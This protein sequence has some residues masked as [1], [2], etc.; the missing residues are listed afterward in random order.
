MD[1][2]QPVTPASSTELQA[3]CLGAASL[4][5]PR[6]GC[7]RELVLG[8]GK[9]LA[10]LVYLHSAPTR[11][12]SREHL[13]DLLWADLDPTA[14][15]HALRQTLWYLRQRLGPDSIRTDNG[16][17]ALA[18]DLECDRDDFVRAVTDG[19][20]E[21]AVA[22][23]AGHFLAE[24]AVPGGLEFE[25]WAEAE[26]TRL[27]L[28]YLRAAESVVRQWLSLGHVREA[29]E[30]AR[31][32]RDLNPLAETAWRLYLETLIAARDPVSTMAEAEID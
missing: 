21:D 32:A 23:Y 24:F 27:R 19:R 22:I 31:Q 20:G 14:A 1:T 10:L 30:L 16:D 11:S 13:T 15:R 26:R 8:P 2:R 17:I 18:L 9:P 7:D 3:T 4:W 25:Y 12:A 29:R 6:D 28:M 5:L